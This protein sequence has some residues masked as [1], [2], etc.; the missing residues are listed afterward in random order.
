MKLF[1]LRPSKEVYAA[2]NED[3]DNPWE[4]WYDKTFGYVIRAK[5]EKVA[6]IIAQHHGSDEVFWAN[7]KDSNK[8]WDTTKHET[9]PW[10]DPTYSSCVELVPEGP[11]GIIIRDDHAA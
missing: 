11:V 6:R 1:L 4:P 2:M 8:S 5:N 7:M 3:K 9:I 10:L